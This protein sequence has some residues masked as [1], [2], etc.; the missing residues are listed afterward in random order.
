MPDGTASR[1]RP[2]RSCDY[3]TLSFDTAAAD[4][5]KTA[6]SV[7]NMTDSNLKPFFDRGGKLLM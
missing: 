7:L 6:G 2:A 4:A 3:K 5:D 1:G